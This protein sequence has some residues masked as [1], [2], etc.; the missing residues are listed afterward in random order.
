MSGR[1][2][3][4]LIA[5][6]KLALHL[7]TSGR[8]GYHRDELY[9][10]ACADHLDFGYV[11]HPPMIAWLAA[12]VRTVLGE[13]LLAIRLLP[14][15]AG[16]VTVVVTGMM[17]RRLGGDRFAQGLSALAVLIAPVYLRTGNML[18]IPAFEALLWSIASYL[19][20]VILQENR[21]RLWLAAGLVAGVGLLFKFTMLLWGFGLVVGLLLTPVRRQ[22]AGKW[23]WLGG[24]VT[25]LL[26][27]PNLLWQA[28]HDWPSI[29]FM[30]NLNRHTLSRISPLEFAFGQVLYP[31]P[32]NFPVWMA[33]LLSLLFLQRF[34]PYRVLG[35]TYVVIYIVLNITNG[36]LYYICPFYPVLF[37]A[38]AVFIEDWSKHRLAPWF[39]P[40]AIGAMALGGAVF[41][42][43]GLPL[44][45]IGSY[46]RYARILTGG[47]LRNIHEVVQDFFD[48]HGW[49]NQVATVSQ[50]FHTLSDEDRSRCTIIAGNYGQAAAIDFFGT[51]YGIPKAVSPHMSYHLWGPRNETAEVAIVIGSRREN[52]EPFFEEITEAAVARNE[53][54]VRSEAERPVYLC[55]RPKVVLQDVW[56]AMKNYN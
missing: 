9:F 19:V 16:A 55:R 27:L 54:S 36:K 13:S 10:L 6:T 35:L 48:M 39:R 3:V 32:M 40:L 12:G 42:P 53:I 14:A 47:L 17:V 50:V 5:L 49:E 11:D 18:H 41:A 7:L 24:G 25:L 4:F 52:L 31:H 34:R 37:S 22:F 44:L 15:L 21:P 38:G 43:V 29:E 51:R 33:G 45:P 2:I 1:T 56:P 28:T 23:I 8:Y 46:D 26:F 20:I 30:R